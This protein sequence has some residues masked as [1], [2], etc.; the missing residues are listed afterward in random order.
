VEEDME[1][2]SPR[3]F[4]RRFM[5]ADTGQIRMKSRLLETVE[6]YLQKN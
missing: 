5:S 6:K 1:E 2:Q 3:E 4:L